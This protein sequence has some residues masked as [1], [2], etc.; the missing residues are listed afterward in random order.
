MMILFIKG[1]I[2]GLGKIIPGVSGALLAINFNVYEQAL[3]ALTNFFSNWKKNLKFLLILSSGIFI[4][5]V[6]GSKIILYLL[7]Y[8]KFITMT[9]FIGL[10]MGGTYNFS[11]KITYNFKTTIII[12]PL[13]IIISFLLNSFNS[14][15]IYLLKNNYKD[16]LIFL[17]GGFI[18]IFSSLIPGISG[19]ALQ[20]ILGIYYNILNMISNIFN[21]NYVITNLNLYLSFGLGLFLSFIICTYLINY[22][23]KKYRETTNII[24]LSLSITSILFLVVMTIKI[25]FTIIE[26]ILGIM[27]LSLGFLLSTIL[28]K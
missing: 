15:N 1:L 7:N 2:I 12:L 5:I 6:L 8:H 28:D 4:S 20:M 24:I 10:I 22:F 16:N 27:L 14:S 25:K 18:E 11:K 21:I 26:L 13:L 17:L 23:L 3:D 9:F 19:T